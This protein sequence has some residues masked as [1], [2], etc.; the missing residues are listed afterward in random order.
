MSTVAVA[1][2]GALYPP[3][4]QT[5]PG[6]PPGFTAVDGETVRGVN[7]AEIHRALLQFPSQDVILCESN[8]VSAHTSPLSNSTVRNQP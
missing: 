6:C 4:P 2:S 7:T 5:H 1:Q 3:L 8:A